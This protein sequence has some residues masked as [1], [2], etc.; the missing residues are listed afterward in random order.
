LRNEFNEIDMESV[1]RSE[2][3]ALEFQETMQKSA[4]KLALDFK[5]WQTKHTNLQSKYE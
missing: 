5:K 4:A 1:K 3:I 2:T